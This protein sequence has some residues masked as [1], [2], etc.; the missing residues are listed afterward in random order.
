MRLPSS[1]TQARDS[2]ASIPAILVLIFSTGLGSATQAGIA[3]ANPDPAPTLRLRVHAPSDRDLLGAAARLRQERTARRALSP[4]A[5]ESLSIAA[6]RVDF[7]RDSDPGTTGDGKFDLSNPGGNGLDRPPHDR[8]YF[9]RQLLAL[10]NYW[11]TVSGGRLELVTTVFPEE[12]AAAFTL[13]HPMAFYNP[14]TTAAAKEVRLAE[15][16]RDAVLAG[17]PGVEFAAFDAVVIFH[18]GVGQDLVLDDSTPNDLPSAFLSFRELKTALAPDD[19]DF[20]GI[21]VD[22]GMFF[23]RDGMWAP[24]TEVQELPAPIGTIEFSLH[25]VVASLFGSQLGLPSL[26]NTESG[27]PGIGRFGL[28]DQGAGNELGKLPAAPCAWSRFFLGFTDPVVLRQGTDVRLHASLLGPIEDPVFIPDLALLPIDSREYYLIENRQQE[29]DGEPG[30][31]L[32]DSLGTVIGV[33]GKEYDAAIPGSGLL[34]WHI[35]EDA[36]RAG[37]DRNTVNN[38]YARRGVDLEEADGTQDIG[39]RADGGFGRPEDCYRAGNATRFAADTSP[40]S[41]TNWGAS[42]HIAVE[43]VGE[44]AV[45]M[46]FDVGVDIAQPGFPDST[47]AAGGLDHVSLTSGDIDDLDDN[48]REIAFVTPGGQLVALTSEAIPLFPPVALGD[49]AAGT[50]PFL[51]DLDPALLGLEIAVATKRGIR[52]L[53][54]DG[55]AAGTAMW[56]RDLVSAPHG[57]PLA[58]DVGGEL[59][60][61]ALDRDGRLHLWRQDVTIPGFP[62]AAGVAPRSNLALIDSTLLFAAGDELLWVT[63]GAAGT[64]EV[65]RAPAPGT[66]RLWL[67]PGSFTREAAEPTLALASETEGQVWLLDWEGRG[68]PGWPRP[69]GERHAGPPAAADLDADGEL[70][71]VIGGEGRVWALSGSGAAVPG[72]PAE[73]RRGSQGPALTG[74]PVIGDAD[75]DGRLDII[76]GAP[77]GG[78]HAFAA[79]G[80]PLFGFPLPAGD[81]NLGSPILAELDG[82]GR[83]EIATAAADGWL[84]AFELPGLGADVAWPGYGGPEGAF[85]AQVALGPALPLASI[86]PDDSITIYPNPS[87]GPVHIRFRSA[88]G[89]AVSISVMDALGRPVRH[90]TA[91]AGGLGE[92]LWDGRD[93][94]GDRAPSGIYVCHIAATNGGE[95][96]A[97][98]RSIAITR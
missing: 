7:V 1:P 82:D 17:D 48:R 11:R 35:D 67:L 74:S 75:A 26:F 89:T 19:P 86:L 45:I 83:I 90:L 92:I 60:L 72:W 13:P 47:F 56:S 8:D 59:A 24:E 50:P 32:I 64:P 18:A 62:L 91:A 77:E 41:L 87:S 81:A 5:P 63:P 25:G 34:I 44:S 80:S 6:I 98:L 36:I 33:A 65:R 85:T 31:A 49:S 2:H 88:A 52:V 9:E 40:S 70:D 97:H 21:P 20:A 79:D 16:F 4:T 84:H 53:A 58:V 42:T 69:T 68:L 73:L 28:M 37:I 57:G 54:A 27:A 23:V 3:A 38:D 61:A 55:S 39:L 10:E 94:D 51:A 78:L 96:I 43:N 66:G 15:F 14:D 46:G 93:E 29:L 12:A 30:F 22:G 71:F 95:S 76:V